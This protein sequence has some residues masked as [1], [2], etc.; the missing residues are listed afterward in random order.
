[1]KSF[2]RENPTIA[3]GLG[4]PILL[5]ITFLL[6]SGIPSLLVAQPQYD[7]IYATEYYDDQDGLLINVINQKVQV[8]HQD[9]A[10]NNRK[11][12]LL[13]YFSKTG[14]VQE[15]PII[16]PAGL[17]LNGPKPKSPEKD[18]SKRTLIKISDLESLVI[19]SSSIAPDGYEFILGRGRYSNNNI[20]GSLFYSSR[21]RHQGVLAKNGRSIR[22][23]NPSERY[24]GRNTHFIGWVVS[25]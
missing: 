17:T 11:P 7:V 9:N 18:I 6:V 20:F 5:V 14:D 23:P 2:L 16:L 8:I 13:R 4:L 22:L 1:M 25:P 10:R 3:F 24:Y 21:N 15:I 12:R 19:D